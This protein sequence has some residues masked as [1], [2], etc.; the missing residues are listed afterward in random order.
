LDRAITVEGALNHK[1]SRD[2]E[3]HAFSDAI[4]TTLNIKFTRQ[5]LHGVEKARAEELVSMK[6]ANPAWT[7]RV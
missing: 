5:D 6:Y 1:I 4:Q 7:N 3:A 2:I